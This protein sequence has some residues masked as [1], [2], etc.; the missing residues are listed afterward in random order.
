MNPDTKQH[1]RTDQTAS[2]DFQQPPS[3]RHYGAIRRWHMTDTRRYWFSTPQFGFGY[4]APIT[5]EGW[6]VDLAVFATF[7]AGGLWIR[8]HRQDHPM[9]QLAFF[10][11]TLAA[12]GMIQHWKGEPKSWG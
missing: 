6:T 11:G 3:Q 12:T 8:G 9:L 1:S 7:V 5:W 2:P 10:F 4:R